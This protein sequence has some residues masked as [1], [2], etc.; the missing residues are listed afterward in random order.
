MTR[1]WALV[2]C[3]VFAAATPAAA[4][5]KNYK[6]VTQQDL[7]HPSPDDW[8]MFSRTYDAFRDSPLSQINTK[9]VKNLRMAWVRGLGEGTTETIPLVHDGVMYVIA[10]GGFV[11]ALDATNG[12]LIWEYKRPFKNPQLGSAE[13]TKALAIYKDMIYF[14]AADGYVVALDARD[15]H[16]RWETFKTDTQNTSGALVVDGKVISG[17]TCGRGSDSCFIEADDADTGEKVWRFYTVAHPDDPGFASWN[18]PDNSQMMAST[19]GLPGTFDPTRNVLYWGVAN[20]MPDQRMLRH[21][22]D[23]DGTSRKTPSDL[24]SNCTLALD[25]ATGKLIWYYQHLPGDDWDTDHTHERTLARVAF[26]PNPKFVK[27]INSTVP[28][29][30]MHDI[31][32]MVAEGG[33]LFVLD[34]DNGKFLWATPFPYDDP[35]YIMSDVDVKTGQT[36]LNW[37]LVFKH[38]GDHHIM[39]YWNTR[40]YWPTAYHEE[41]QSLFV[42]YIDNCRDLTTNGPGVKGGWKVI[43]RPGSDPNALTGLARINLSTGETL[44]FDVGRAPSNGAMLTT[45]GGLVFH[46]DMSR[47]F[48]AFDVKT[49]EKLWEG[50]VGGNV[51]VSTITYAINGKQY[52]CVMT[53]YNPKVP[54]LSAEVPDMRTPNTSNAIYVFSLP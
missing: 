41:T 23:P 1:I 17:G 37:D 16:V 51:S 22:G 49:G 12:D 31:A 40:S 26:N 38:P 42:P 28:R 46:G 47:R 20:P 52:I 25:P 2:V 48:R 50:I 11:D 4:Q 54:E 44:H 21:N 13:R 27:W 24:Y 39:C 10:P 53:G 19:W 15:G 3:S 14:T 32:A 34:R 5:V 36:T 6:P 35:N 7:L 43:P 18:L 30:S 29:G 9:N 45:A 8:L 33:T